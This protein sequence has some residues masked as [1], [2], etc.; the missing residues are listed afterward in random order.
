MTSH[1]AKRH[2][3]ADDTR[4]PSINIAHSAADLAYWNSMIE[5]LNAREFSAWRGAEDWDS[6]Q[7]SL[8]MFIIAKPSEMYNAWA[9][10]WP[11][12]VQRKDADL[13]SFATNSAVSERPTFY[14]K[15][16]CWKVKTGLFSTRFV[17]FIESIFPGGQMPLGYAPAR[18]LNLAF[19]RSLMV[20]RSEEVP[21]RSVR[22]ALEDKEM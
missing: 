2:F 8:T 6:H 10:A 9:N 1:D 7:G 20:L 17:I 13:H 16:Q 22:K 14:Q 3:E 5:F 21:F 19:G 18:R 11:E 15:L 4:L 12:H